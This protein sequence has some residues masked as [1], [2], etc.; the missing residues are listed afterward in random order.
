MRDNK[1]KVQQLLLGI[2]T[3]V[4]MSIVIASCSPK[5][6]LDQASLP[7]LFEGTMQAGVENA[8]PVE[9]DLNAEFPTTPS[10]VAVYEIVPEGISDADATKLVRQIGFIGDAV[11]LKPGSV[12]QVYSFMGGDQTL[13]IGLDGGI[14]IHNRTA[15]AIPADLPTAEKCTTAARDW[16]TSRG[17]YPSDVVRTS[18]SPFIQVDAKTVATVVKFAIAVGGYE[19]QGVGAYVAIG[20]GGRVVEVSRNMPAVEKRGTV[21]LKTPGDALQTL[22]NYLTSSSAS[23]PEAKICSVNM[24]SFPLLSIETVSIQY[25]AGAGYLQ[26]VYVFEGSGFLDRDG[27]KVERFVGLVD[28]VRR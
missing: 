22:W 23:P 13:E 16:L 5:P 17:L 27:T 6:V 15:L 21:K 11:P 26:P 4:A 14:A 20:D 25:K 2:G 3:A 8:P 19:V 7:Y 12:R 24:R 1:V 9:I 18:T 28:A 10:D